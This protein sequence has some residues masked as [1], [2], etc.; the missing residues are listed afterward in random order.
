MGVPQNGWEINIINGIIDYSGINGNIMLNNGNI[1]ANNGWFIIK[2][3]NLKWMM[4]G[5]TSIF[6]NHHMAKVMVAKS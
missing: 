3:L 6:G 5:A 2:H 1:V 4:A